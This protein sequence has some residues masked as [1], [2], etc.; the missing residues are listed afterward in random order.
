MT[1]SQFGVNLSAA[2]TQLTAAN[3]VQNSLT[4]ADIN[5]HFLN[6]TTGPQ[7]VGVGAAG[8]VRITNY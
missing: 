7:K 4:G 8:G 5:G 3:S 2:A 1:G 6:T